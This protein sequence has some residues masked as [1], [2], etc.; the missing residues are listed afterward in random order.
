[1]SVYCDYLL[2]ADASLSYIKEKRV[3][4]ADMIQNS[5][6]KPQ[7]VTFFNIMSS[8]A[9]IYEYSIQTNGNL[10]LHVHIHRSA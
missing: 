2:V 6:E 4:H 7:I 10:E 8:A 1:M 9:N 3:Q 5:R